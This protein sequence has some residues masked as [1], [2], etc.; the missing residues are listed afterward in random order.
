M[1]FD[2]FWFSIKQKIKKII[3]I[4]IN[5]EKKKLGDN[6]GRLTNATNA[7]RRLV[8]VGALRAGPVRLCTGHVMILSF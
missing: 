7:S 5:N 1:C 6:S 2:D 3:E 4:S 8:Q